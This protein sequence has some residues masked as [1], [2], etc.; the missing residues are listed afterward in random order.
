M[1]TSEETSSPDLVALIESIHD[2]WKSA[3]GIRFVR[4]AAEELVAE[5]TV[6]PEHLQPLGLVH[7]GV[8]A[9]LIETVASVGASLS[10]I[11]YGKVA[12]GLEN[13]TSFLHGVRGGSLRATGRPLAKG[14]RSQVWQVDVHDEQGRLVST[15]RVRLLVIDQDATLPRKPG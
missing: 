13:H 4:A 2:G 11:P 14:K 8:H 15:G 7:G 3:M 5:L 12:V 10:V 9:G 1:S 6:G